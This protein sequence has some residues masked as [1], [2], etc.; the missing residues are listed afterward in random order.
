M[1]IH[2]QPLEAEEP[3]LAASYGIFSHEALS[4]VEKQADYA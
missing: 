2:G 1:F 3:L 4:W